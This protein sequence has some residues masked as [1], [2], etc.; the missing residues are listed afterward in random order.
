MLLT[1]HYIHKKMHDPFYII[2]FNNKSNMNKK[3]ESLGLTFCL[4]QII[5]Y[6]M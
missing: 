5:V 3:K 2:F 1:I 6:N 4:L